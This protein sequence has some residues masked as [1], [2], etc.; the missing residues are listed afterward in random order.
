MDEYRLNIPMDVFNNIIS[1]MLR[2]KPRIQNIKSILMRGI[3]EDNPDAVRILFELDMLDEI[4]GALQR[5]VECEST[6]ILNWM[7]TAVFIDYEYLFE[8]AVRSSKIRVM[9]WVICNYKINISDYYPISVI[10]MNYEVVQWFVDKGCKL[11]RDTKDQIISEF[12]FDVVQFMLS[13]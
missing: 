11:R 9:D 6:E 13:I 5:I 10:E 7:R 4:P 1:S 2:E 3:E 8:L 12:G